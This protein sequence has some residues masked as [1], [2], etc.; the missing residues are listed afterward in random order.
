MD[1]QVA[2]CDRTGKGATE[3]ESGADTEGTHS[4]SP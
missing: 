1:E 2:L 4:P 3:I